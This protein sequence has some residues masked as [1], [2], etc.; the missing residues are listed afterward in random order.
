MALT[1]ILAGNPVPLILQAGETLVITLA[2]NSSGSAAVPGQSVSTSMT[3]GGAYSFGPYAVQREVVVTLAAGTA[4]VDFSGDASG[5]LTPSQV[6]WVQSSVSGGG[7]PVTGADVLADTAPA[8]PGA[9]PG[10]TIYY[11]SSAA[12]GVDIGTQ[13]VWIPTGHATLPASRG[14]RFAFYPSATVV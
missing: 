2:T 1:T 12:A 3:A 6:A 14:W 10:P 11:V 9:W 5:G 4:T 13:V 7:T 8:N